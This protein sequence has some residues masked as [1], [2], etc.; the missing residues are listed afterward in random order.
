MTATHNLGFPRI[1]ERRELKKATEAYW[2]GDLDRAGLDAAGAELRRSNWEKQQHA[3]IDLIPSND[4]S[5][6]DQVLVMSCL[7]GNVPARFDW[8][9]GNAD[10]DVA[11]DVAR[12]I[13]GKDEAFAAEMTKWFETNY[14]YIVP[15]FAADTTFKL[16]ASKVFDQFNE[17]LEQG[18]KTKP[19]LIGPATYLTL[20]KVVNGSDADKFDLFERLLPV[21]VEV[22]E[23]L[24]E[25]GADWIQIDEP[26][27][28]LD[29]DNTQRQLLARSYDALSQ[30][31]GARILVANYFGEL[32]DN[33]D[34]FVSLPVAGLHI[35]AVRGAAE[36]EAVAGRIGGETQLSVGVVDGRNVW[37]TDFERALTVLRK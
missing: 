36:V 23:K 5:F 25:A 30:V 17:A 27:F 8:D 4:F 21:Y 19:V 35:D 34:L 37:K 26:I 13:R 14:H 20:G 7:L 28:A 29:L 32:R 9:G 11:F 6:Y 1:G 16:S 31:A 18:I 12:G 10:V 15:E 22:V 33:L 2:K 3:G 24:V